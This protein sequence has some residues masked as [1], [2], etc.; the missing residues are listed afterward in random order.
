MLRAVDNAL[1]TELFRDLKDIV[2]GPAFDWNLREAT[3]D[4]LQSVED[5]DSLNL[6]KFV[7]GD[8]IFQNPTYTAVYTMLK[9]ALLN[10][11][12]KIEQDIFR[13]RFALQFSNKFEKV[14]KPHIDSDTPHKVGLIYLNDSDGDTIFYNERFDYGM[15]GASLDDVVR[16]KNFTE[17][18]RVSPKENRMAIF[19]G[20]IFHSSSAPIDSKIRCIVNFNYA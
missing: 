3:Y 13:I 7:Y 12:E 16:G 18:T 9:V 8:E 4:T 5:V 19:D 10:A 2:L 15:Q 11:G 17:M 14:N 6:V 20:S 1:Q